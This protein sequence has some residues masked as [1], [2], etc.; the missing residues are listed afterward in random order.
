MDEASQISVPAC[1]GPLRLASSFLLVGDHYQLPPLVRSRQA[2]SE[3]LNKS[4]FATLAEAHPQSVS[5][6]RLQ[7]RMNSDIMAISN[8][9]VYGGMLQC[10]L[11]TVSNARMAL[12]NFYSCTCN[13][14]HT[15]CWLSDTIAPQKTVLFLDTD[16]LRAYESPSG[17]S[18][19]NT[20][21]AGIV[22]SV[23][24]SLVR[25]GADV[26]ELSVISPYRP[27]LKLL[28]DAATDETRAIRFSTV[29]KFQGMDSDCII[30]S[31]VRSNPDSSIGQLLRD[32]NRLNVA[33]TRARKKLILVGSGK[34]ILGNE[35]FL[36]LKDLFSERGWLH[37]LP[38]DAL[39]HRFN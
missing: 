32:W 1:I 4:L 27:Q 11:D 24:N 26:N 6:L 22:W 20:A 8:T 23:L 2:V 36:Q 29:D 30:I 7:Y 33:F 21:E 38:V 19:I 5:M 13:C 18:F 25:A 15:A 12:P 14:S 3:G 10:G 16:A 39:M 35:A 34:T 9:F 31:M 28:S 37:Q 17:N